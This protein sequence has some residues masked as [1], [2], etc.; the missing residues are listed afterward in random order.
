MFYLLLELEDS[1]VDCLDK[2]GLTSLSNLLTQEGLQDTLSNQMQQLTLFAPSNEAL[3]VVNNEDTDDLST[4]LSSHTAGRKLRATYLT[5][6][7]KI[8]SLADGRFIH[9]TVVKV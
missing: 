9:T 7:L 1:V 5:G 6:G 2:L 3:A 8:P 4:L